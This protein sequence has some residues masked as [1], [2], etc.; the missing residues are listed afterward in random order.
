MSME[1]P[2]VL[3]NQAEFTMPFAEV[4]VETQLD[5]QA[6]LEAGLN[7]IKV[8]IAIWRPLNLN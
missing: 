6:H 8:Q 7:S 2:V 5:L 1:E 3:I 4:V